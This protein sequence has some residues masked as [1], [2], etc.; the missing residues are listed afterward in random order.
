MTGNTDYAMVK[1]SSKEKKKRIYYFLNPTKEKDKVYNMPI[2]NFQKGIFMK[3]QGNLTPER[4]FIKIF[5]YNWNNR[6][7]SEVHRILN[8]SKYIPEETFMKL[9]SFTGQVIFIIFNYFLKNS[10][11]CKNFKKLIK[12]RNN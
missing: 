5:N 4:N 9:R 6:S 3:I 2:K 8:A 10:I 11:F 1:H 12:N 7:Y